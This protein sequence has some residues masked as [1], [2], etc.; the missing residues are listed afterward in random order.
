MDL[1]LRPGTRELIKA[2]AAATKRCI[3]V[4]RVVPPSPCRDG[5]EEVGATMAWYLGMEGGNAIAD[6]PPATSIPAAGSHRLPG[7]HRPASP[8]RQEGGNDRIWLLSRLSPLRPGGPEP[9]A[10]SFGFG[11]SYT[12][13]E[14]TGLELG[15]R[16][17]RSG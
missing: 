6:I 16:G 9:P 14:Y 13:Y 10:Y 15:A 7:V 5:R 4:L 8:F 1:G 12:R 11:L 2:V 17:N 3:V